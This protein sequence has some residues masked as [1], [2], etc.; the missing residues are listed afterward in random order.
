MLSSNGRVWFT[1]GS[2][3]YLLQNSAIDTGDSAVTNASGQGIAISPFSR[4]TS[5][6]LFVFRKA[7]ID[8][9]DVFGTTAIEALA[10]SNGWKTMNA[11]AGS[12]N[13]H[14]AIKAQDDVIYFCDDRYTGSILEN[15]AQP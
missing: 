10:W 9:I 3:A 15:L 8:V 14:H 6:D 1:S 11:G 13:S 12:G 4:T 5:T 2:R 7:I